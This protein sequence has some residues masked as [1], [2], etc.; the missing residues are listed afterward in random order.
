MA[1]ILNLK[2][3]NQDLGATDEA[4]A[5]ALD[6]LR[7][8]RNRPNFGNAGEV[9]NQLS[10]AKNIFQARQSGMKAS[11]RMYEVTFEPQDFDSDFN[12]G[13]SAASNLQKIFKDIIGCEEVVEKLDGYQKMT[14]GLKARGLEPRETVPTNFL[15]KGPLVGVLAW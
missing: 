10:L 1:E 9:E 2:L 4:K 15:F 12:R 7:R 13:A 14:Q 6:V 11:E 8:A 5:V 3:K